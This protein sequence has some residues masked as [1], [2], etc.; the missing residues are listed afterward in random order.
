MTNDFQNYFDE[1][2]RKPNKKCVVKG[3]E[4]YNGL[5]KSCLKD[6]GIEM[7]SAHNEKKY[8]VAKWFIGI[9]KNKIHKLMTSVSKN[10]YT[11]KLDFVLN[12]YISTYYRTIKIK[13]V[14]VDWNTYFDCDKK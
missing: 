12:K 4:S 8:I 11:N 14:K 13:P 7:Y 2:E 3:S 9:L 5:I 10:V 1:P 6:N